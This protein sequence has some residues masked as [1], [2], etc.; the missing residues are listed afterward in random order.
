MDPKSRTRRRDVVI[1][2]SGGAFQPFHYSTGVF[3]SRFFVEL[4]DNK[5]LMGVRCPGCRK[6][7]VPPRPL[8]GPCYLPTSEWV[9][10]G[11]GGVLAAFT[12]LRFAFLD[13]ETGEKKPVPYGYGFIKL[14][15]ADTCFQH[16]LD[17]REGRPP[18][19]GMRLRPVFEENRRGNLRDIR[20]FEPEG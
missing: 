10:V 20:H 14:D 16:F 12:I 11:P 5:R 3:G 17:L 15:G 8:C 13:P 19:I 6:V 2:T 4:R 9:E 18:K 7:Y 1:A